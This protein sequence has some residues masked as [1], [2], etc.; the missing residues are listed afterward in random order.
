M[1]TDKKMILGFFKD[2]ATFDQNRL[3]IS[4]HDSCIKWANDLF[5]HFNKEII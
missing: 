1:C 4:T 5:Y 2:D 3:L